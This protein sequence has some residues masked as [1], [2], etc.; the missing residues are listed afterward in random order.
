MDF[1]QMGRIMNIVFLFFWHCAGKINC[2]KTLIHSPVRSS[3]KATKLVGICGHFEKSE[4]VP[5]YN[6]TI[7]A[8]V[9]LFI[10]GVE[11]FSEE[12]SIKAHFSSVVVVGAHPNVN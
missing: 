7:R 5:L 4:D 11:V 12:Y 10:T 1:F 3:V 9:W 6:S 2:L 8:G